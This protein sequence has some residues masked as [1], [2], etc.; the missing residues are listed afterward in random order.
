MKTA[1]A[2]KEKISPTDALMVKVGR[3]IDWFK[4][5]RGAYTLERAIE[6]FI[7]I[8][9]T[10]SNISRI[11]EQDTKMFKE[12]G[13]PVLKGKK[14]MLVL[15]KTNRS[16]FDKEAFINDYGETAYA[17]YLKNSTVYEWDI[18]PL[19]VVEA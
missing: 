10:K 6:D 16:C 7:I 14:N 18:V 12:T 9:D 4:A 8:K 17:K 2:T 13:K 5:N 19:N 11:Y 15:K 3:V 1:T